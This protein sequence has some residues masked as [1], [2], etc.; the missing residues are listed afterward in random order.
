MI[1]PTMI[2]STK[3]SSTPR[4][5]K[6]TTLSFVSPSAPS[7]APLPLPKPSAIAGALS[8][9]DNRVVNRAVVAIR[10]RIARHVIDGTGYLAVDGR[11]VQKRRSA[12]LLRR[13]SEGVT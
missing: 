2:V 11:R 3:K 5:K 13:D 4:Q 10:L 9:S 6:V 7:P 1:V 12:P 8:A